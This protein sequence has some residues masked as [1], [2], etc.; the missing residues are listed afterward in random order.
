[1]ELV[2]Y[3][4]VTETTIDMMYVLV[5]RLDHTKHMQGTFHNRLLTMGFCHRLLN[6]RQRYQF[7]S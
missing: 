6:H 4:H 3:L 5:T 7:S 2:I 1:M